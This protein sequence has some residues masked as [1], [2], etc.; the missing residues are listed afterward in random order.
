MCYLLDMSEFS[1]KIRI[2]NTVRAEIFAGQIFEVFIF[3]E[4]MYTQNAKIFLDI[5]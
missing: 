3:H 4:N 2:K 1:L 5:S